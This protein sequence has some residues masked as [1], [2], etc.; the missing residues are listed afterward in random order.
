MGAID[1]THIALPETH[2]EL[3]RGVSGLRRQQQ[4]N[5]VGHQHIG[6]EDTACVARQGA[7]EFEIEGAV[8]IAR[9]AWHAVDAALRDMGRHAGL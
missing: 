3:G 4:V 8:I 5:M 9:E 1:R 7:E 2:H 6:M